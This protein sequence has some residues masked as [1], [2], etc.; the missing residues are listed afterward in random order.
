VTRISHVFFVQGEKSLELIQS[1]LLM[2]LFY[3]PPNG[4]RQGQYYQYAHIAATMAFEL[5]LTS[6]FRKP[7]D[8]I[9]EGARRTYRLEQAR[10]IIG[11]HHFAS[12]YDSDNIRPDSDPD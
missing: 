8:W 5:G 10:A 7:D 4:S 3:Y 9:D 2:I 1:L 11:C 12:K 6:D